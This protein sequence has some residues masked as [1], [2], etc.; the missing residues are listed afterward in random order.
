MTSNHSLYKHPNRL[1]RAT[2][3]QKTNSSYTQRINDLCKKL[4]LSINKNKDYKKYCQKVNNLVKWLFENN[5]AT[6]QEVSK[7]LTRRKELG[8]NKEEKA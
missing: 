1:A 8:L 5:R 2:E 7:F 3:I 6:K 4:E